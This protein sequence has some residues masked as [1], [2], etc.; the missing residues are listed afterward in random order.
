M[1]AKRLSLIYALAIGVVAPCF[2]ACSDDPEVSPLASPE[3]SVNSRS[4]NTL[5]FAWDRIDNAVQYGYQLEDPSGEVVR[6]GVVN[7]TSVTLTDLE[8]ATTYT[9]NVW[10]YAAMNSGY[11]TA[12]QVTLTATTDPLIGLDIP[13]ATLVSAGSSSFE[14]SWTPVAGADAYAYKVVGEDYLCVDTISAT[15]VTVRNID[16]GAY[17][18]SVAAISYQPGYSNSD[19]SQPIQ[20]SGTRV[21]LWTAEG[22]YYSYAYN[23]TWDASIAAYDDGTYSILSWYG[24][25]GYNFSFSIDNSGEYGPFQME[26]G[27]FDASSWL[28]AVPTGVADFP[29][30]DVYPYYDYSYMQ[31][32][33]SA[34]K[35]NINHWYGGNYVNDYFEWSSSID[36]LVGTYDNILSGWEYLDDWSEI[37]Q[38]VT[39]TISKIDDKTISIEGLF[40]SSYYGDLPLEATVNLSEMTITIDPQEYGYYQFAG[41]NSATEVVIGTISDDMSIVF[42][43]FN[44]WYDWG[45]NYGWSYYLSDMKAILVKN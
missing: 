16:S 18:F 25:E 32:N 11:S 29:Q 43:N 39:A 4:F 30:L 6:T 10:A 3:L 33:E 5:A 20:F 1:K 19:Y 44:L 27:T 23:S 45:G 26:C 42:R 13:V 38:T 15:S 31:G 21:R 40:S 9:L 8:P 12:P 41:D 35:V 36:V 2:T 28:Y 22:T 37:N 24:V 14:F 17:E 34:G 7:T